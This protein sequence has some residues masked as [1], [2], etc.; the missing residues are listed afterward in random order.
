[1]TLDFVKM[2]GLGN[3]FVLIDARALALD[4]LPG[5]SKK[6]LDRRFGIG[7]DQLLLL[8]ESKAADFRMRIFNPDGGEIEMCGNGV[9]CSPDP[10]A[11]G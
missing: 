9:R 1:M 5:L 6:L 11:A 10:P 7:A 3:D 4:D 8:L 2:H